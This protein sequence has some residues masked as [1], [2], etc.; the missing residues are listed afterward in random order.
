MPKE[1]AEG[2]RGRSYQAAEGMCVLS[3]LMMAMVSQVHMSK[4]IAYQ[5]ITQT[6]N[7]RFLTHQL[8]RNKSAQSRGRNDN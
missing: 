1:S 3:I 5:N 4:S 7:A 8:Y 2:T 6:L